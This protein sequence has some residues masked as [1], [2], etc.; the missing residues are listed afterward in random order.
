MRL[1]TS[2]APVQA[3]GV[4]ERHRATVRID[5]RLI[6]IEHLGRPHRHRCECFIDFNHVQVSRRELRPF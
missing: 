3:D 5:V 1:T 6:Q 4:A 2:L